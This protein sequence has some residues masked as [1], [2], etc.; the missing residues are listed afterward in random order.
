MWEGE[1]VVWVW[2]CEDVMVWEWESDGV[3]M[4]E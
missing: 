4:G 1:G 2:E 3:G